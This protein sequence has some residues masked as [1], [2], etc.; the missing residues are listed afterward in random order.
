MQISVIFAEVWHKSKLSV[1]AGRFVPVYPSWTIFFQ[2]YLPLIRFIILF[3]HQNLSIENSYV[4][5]SQ[6][7]ADI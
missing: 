7:V 5:I 4:Q 3:D 1:M 6:I 2:I